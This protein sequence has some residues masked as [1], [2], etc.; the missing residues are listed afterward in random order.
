MSKKS[1]SAT[2]AKNRQLSCSRRL[3]LSL[4]AVL[5][6]VPAAHAFQL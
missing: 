3:S 5:A 2:G 4:P 1:R 6:V